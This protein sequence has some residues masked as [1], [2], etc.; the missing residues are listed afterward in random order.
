MTS[1]TP[2]RMS[3]E[4]AEL[5]AQCDA[6]TGY[7]GLI[8][9]LDN[10]QTVTARRISGALLATLVP[11]G[12]AVPLM[13]WGHGLVQ[14]LALVPWVAS[15]RAVRWLARFWASFREGERLL[16]LLTAQR[17]AERGRHF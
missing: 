6:A 5:L 10:A 13:L 11:L 9:L 7:D 12:V 14:W 2:R 15:A 16:R 17:D 3:D 8:E 1:N 4:T